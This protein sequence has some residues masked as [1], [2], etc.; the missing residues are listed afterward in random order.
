MPVGELYTARSGHYFDHARSR[1]DNTYHEHSLS[2][3]IQRSP[4][5]KSQGR[6]QEK[7]RLLRGL[8][9]VQLYFKELGL[10]VLSCLSARSKSNFSSAIKLVILY[11]IFLLNIFFIMF[12]FLLQ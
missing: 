3:S 1:R 11:Y 10:V 8:W 2:D 9:R 4:F 7:A 12:L 5:R 6:G